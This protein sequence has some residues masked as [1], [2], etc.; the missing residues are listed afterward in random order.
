M[1]H[2]YLHSFIQTLNS[3]YVGKTHM[4]YLSHQTNILLTTQLTTW[5]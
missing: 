3:Q 1:N 4:S 2:H 5:T